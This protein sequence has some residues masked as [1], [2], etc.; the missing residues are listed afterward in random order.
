MKK[1]REAKTVAFLGAGNMAEAII[2]G[3]LGASLFRPDALI[4][5]D[6]LSSRLAHV[7]GTYKVRT[8]LSNCEAV[9]EADVVIV[10]VKP[11]GVEGVLSEVGSLLNGKLLI[12]VAAGIP[13]AR[14]RTHL[15]EEVAVIRAMPNAAALVQRGATVLSAGLFIESAWMDLALSIFKSIGKAWLL[16]ESLL[17]AVTGLSGSGPAYVMVVIEALAEGGVKCGLDYDTALSLATQTVLGASHWL[18]ETAESPDRLKGFVSSPGGTTIAGLAR[19]EAGGVREALI[20]AVEAAT[21]RSKE[22]GSG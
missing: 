1:K 8:T 3:V 7:G 13:L 18:Q 5:S 22:L 10:G 2:K 6:I 12:S 4:A 16:D 15:T 11:K 21:K 9:S 20:A 17:D 14:L 19:I